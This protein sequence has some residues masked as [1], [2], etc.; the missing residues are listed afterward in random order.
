VTHQ[1]IEPKTTSQENQTSHIQTPSQAATNQNKN[2][3]HV[4]FPVTID[5][6]PDDSGDMDIHV[7]RKRRREEEIKNKPERDASI[8]HFLSAGPGSQDCREQ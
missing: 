5:D 8:Q 3:V 1:P 2:H 4:P 7:E 6:E